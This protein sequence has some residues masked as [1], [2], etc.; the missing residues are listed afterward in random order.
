MLPGGHKIN[1]RVRFGWWLQSRRGSAPASRGQGEM[2]DKARDAE[3]VD[4]VFCKQ[5]EVAVG[6]L[7]IGLAKCEIEECRGSSI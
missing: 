6:R 1:A 2:G 5:C 7:A 4:A 3:Q